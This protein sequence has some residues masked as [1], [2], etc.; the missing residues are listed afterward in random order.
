MNEFRNGDAE[1][2]VLG[3]WLQDIKAAESIQ[4]F[5]SEDFTNQAHK[6]LF[7]VLE[8]LYGEKKPFDSVLICTKADSMGYPTAPITAAECLAFTPSSANY[9]RYEEIVL[10]CSRRRFI[11]YQADELKR[12]VGVSENDPEVLLEDF[13]NVTKSVRASSESLGLTDAII[14]VIHKQEIGK[15][16]SVATGFEKLDRFTGGIMPGELT[17]IG[18]RPAVGKSAFAMN[19][20]LNVAKTGKRVLLFS[21]EMTEDS[22]VERMMAREACI[23][24]LKMRKTNLSN[25]E[26][27]QM[28]V[29]GNALHKLPI[30]VVDNARTIEDIS[31]MARRECNGKGVDL[32]IVDYLQLV[33]TKKNTNSIYERVSRISRMLKELAIS[34]NVPVIALAQVKRPTGHIVEMP[35]LSDLRDS[36]SIE[37]DADNVWFLHKPESEADSSV[38]GE[39]VNLFRST[40]GN[41]INDEV[42]LIIFDIAKARSG[43]CG[44][45]P[46][47]YTGKYIDFEEWHNG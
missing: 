3:C 37:Q 32:L 17:V 31:L 18:A 29:H 47:V 1:K 5:T 19:I 13:K 6:E 2:S 23:D 24:S 7:L 4:G 26:I 25:E 8:A 14:R 10:E 38:A 16:N 39:W 40:T 44:K 34:Y 45:L 46:F 41:R 21:L 43:L 27:G 9:E 28:V 36:G 12:N 33:E 35:I 30:S 15:T 11:A 20:A 22:W 42:K